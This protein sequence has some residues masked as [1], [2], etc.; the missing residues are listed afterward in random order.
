[1][2]SECQVKKRCYTR[3]GEWAARRVNVNANVN[4][5]DEEKKGQ[6][7]RRGATRSYPHVSV[8]CRRCCGSAATVVFWLQACAALPCC[9]AKECWDGTYGF[10]GRRMVANACLTSSCFFAVWVGKG[11]AMGELHHPIQKRRTRASSMLQYFSYRKIM[12]IFSR[13]LVHYFAA[14]MRQSSVHI[15]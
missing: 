4:V 7:R 14:T 5:M 12:I 10:L 3:R 2:E 6:V 13:R 11:F 9:P 15:T 8:P 1:M